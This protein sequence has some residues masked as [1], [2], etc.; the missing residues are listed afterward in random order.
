MAKAKY[1]HKEDNKNFSLNNDGSINALCG[2]RVIRSMSFLWRD[3]TC[4][5]CL[6]KKRK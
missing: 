1:I 4:P 2:K 3:I 6:A 5:K